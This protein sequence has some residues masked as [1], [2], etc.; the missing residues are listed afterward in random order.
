MKSGVVFTGKS[1]RSVQ[2]PQ[3]IPRVMK[4]AK[5]F[6]REFLPPFGAASDHS[7]PRLGS[8]SDLFRPDDQ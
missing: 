2:Q 3:D 8:F 5:K 7:E 4:I 6:G 1:A